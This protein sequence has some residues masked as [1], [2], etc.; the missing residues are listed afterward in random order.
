M[1]TNFK[2]NVLSVC[3]CDTH[4]R[5][6]SHLHKLPNILDSLFSFAP[7]LGYLPPRLGGAVLL[8]TPNENDS[9]HTVIIL[10]NTDFKSMGSSYVTL[11]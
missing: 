7:W 1:H 8:S 9:A 4:T 5:T 3:V 6:R 10:T 11:H 2:E